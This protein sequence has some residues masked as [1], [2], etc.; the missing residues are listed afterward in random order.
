MDTLFP[1]CS[2]LIW[3][4]PLLF[5]KFLSAYSPAKFVGSAASSDKPKAIVEIN[6][7]TVVQRLINRNVASAGDWGQSPLA[8]LIRL[9]PPVAAR[10]SLSGERR[11]PACSIRQ[12]AGCIFARRRETKF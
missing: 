2:R 11:L 8:Y 4:T 3:K 6:K 1:L 9:Y 5:R 10:N 12:L 7:A